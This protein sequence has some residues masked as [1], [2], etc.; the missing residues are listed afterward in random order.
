MK[1]GLRKG[2]DFSRLSK[3]YAML[4]ISSVTNNA[5]LFGIVKSFLQYLRGPFLAAI[6]QV[7]ALLFRSDDGIVGR[8]FH[9][10]AKGITDGPAN[11]ATEDLILGVRCKFGILSVMCHRCIAL[12][13]YGTKV[14]RS[15]TIAWDNLEL[16]SNYLYNSAASMCW[17]L[18]SSASHC[19]ASTLMS[20]PL[21]SSGV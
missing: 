3:T 14:I 19:G 20:G 13:V 4:F 12:M 6:F 15:C 5:Y 10:I 8:E 21:D 18:I 17:R 11:H 2:Y 7:P 16:F 1:N 9:R